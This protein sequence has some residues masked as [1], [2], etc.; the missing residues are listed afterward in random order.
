VTGAKTDKQPTCF[1][2]FD[3]PVVRLYNAQTALCEE[4]MSSDSLS[5][6]SLANEV[7]GRVVPEFLG[8]VYAA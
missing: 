1:L 4:I 7:L 3:G 8:A 2:P 6:I 5:N